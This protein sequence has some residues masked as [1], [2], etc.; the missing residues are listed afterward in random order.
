VRPKKSADLAGGVREGG[1]AAKMFVIKATGQQW[2]T[3]DKL[4]QTNR[5]S[6]RSGEPRLSGI[7]V[8]PHFGIGQRALLVRTPTGNVLWDCVP[9]L[10]P[11]LVEMVKAVGG[12]S[13]IAISHPHFYAS[14]VEWSRDFG[15]VPIYLHA[16][17]RQWGNETGQGHRLLGRRYESPGEGL[18]L[19]RCG[20]HFDGGTVHV[21]ATSAKLRP[22]RRRLDRQLIDDAADARGAGGGLH[23]RGA[24]I[25]KLDAA[26]ER[27]VAILRLHIDLA[28]RTDAFHRELL[29]HLLRDRAVLSGSCHG[30]ISTKGNAP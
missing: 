15:D 6:I 23:N 25:V 8:E 16:A 5:N 20:G 29:V 24:L 19:I 22:L 11:A 18:T 2:T 13:S 12:I 3:H 17:D 7:G 27:D 26:G 10:D 9:L 28:G 1:K 4:R 30:Y 21:K 14:M